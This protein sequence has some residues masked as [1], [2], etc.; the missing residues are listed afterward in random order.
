MAGK[1]GFNRED[2]QDLAHDLI[3][4]WL[5]RGHTGQ[6][7]EQGTISR[8]RA[9]FG[10]TNHPKNLFTQA[11]CRQYI[12]FDAK[13]HGGLVEINESKFHLLKFMQS[14][15][16]ST[17]REIIQFFIQGYNLLEIGARISLTE[18]RV[19][20][21]ISA[22]IELANTTNRLEAAKC[23]MPTNQPMAKSIR[24][25]RRETATQLRMQWQGFNLNETLREIEHHW[26]NKALIET[27]WNTE[28]A[29][30]L[31][32]I[33]RTSLVFKLAKLGIER[34]SVK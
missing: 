15:E 22:L 13:L 9:K 10:R 2:R 20:Q 17:D 8:I 5:V 34:P 3:L 28:L 24:Q 16:D 31:L 4:N 33:R 18:S 21:R 12:P 19:S 29:G 1:L 27:N 7:V 23:L 14:I 11:S 6:T 26:I 25:Q 30:Q 32:G